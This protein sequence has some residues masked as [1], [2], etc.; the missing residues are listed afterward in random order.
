MCDV[1]VIN[2][3]LL[4]NYN[5]VYIHVKYLKAKGRM[6]YR[7]HCT[8]QQLQ[9]RGVIQRKGLKRSNTTFIEVNVLCILKFDYL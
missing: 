6:R 1:F 9:K 2:I 4:N 7:F 8:V 5:I 3:K